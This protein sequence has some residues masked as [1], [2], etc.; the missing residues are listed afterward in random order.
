M[1]LYDDLGGAAAVTTAVDLFYERVLADPML[2]PYFM[3]VDVARLRGHQVAFI[4]V[5]LGGPHA[6]AGRSI[7]AA[8]SRL[9]VTAEAFGAVVGH[10]TDTLSGMG[11]D[12]DTL[13]VIAAKLA[14]LESEIVTVTEP[15]A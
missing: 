3:G 5:A 9:G 2:A 4:T 6:Y 12:Q 1:A 15:V 7:S 13:Q 8:H 11:V 14:P 10:L